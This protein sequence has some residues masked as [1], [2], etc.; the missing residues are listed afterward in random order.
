MPLRLS[1]SSS[2]V[3]RS[4]RGDVRTSPRRL[5]LYIAP[6]LR[7]ACWHGSRRVRAK[8]GRSSCRNLRRDELG[9]E[10]RG[11]PRREGLGRGEAVAVGLG[12]LAGAGDEALDTALVAVDVLQDAAGPAGEADTH[13]RA[14][15]GVGDGL[16]DALVDALD[17]LEGLDEEHALLQVLEVDRGGILDRRERV[18]QA[19]PEPRLLAVRV[20]VEPG[21]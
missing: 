17:R 5:R 7:A 20:L 12:Q 18:A 1:P 9:V 14:D 15:I 2:R 16:D 21:A 3:T 8:T 10:V 19:R 11:V 13:D 4:N 6:E